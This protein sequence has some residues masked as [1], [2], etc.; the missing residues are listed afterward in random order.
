MVSAWY[1]VVTDENGDPIEDT[2]GDIIDI[3]DLED[4]DI[5]AFAN[6][7]LRKG[8]EMHEKIGDVDVVQH[9]TFEKQERESLGLGVGVEG[10][11]VK[12]RVN[13]DELWAKIKSGEYAELSIAG[14]AVRES[15]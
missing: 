12:L 8:G 5:D 15:L 13:N 2:Q 3:S 7:G 4:A 10:G 1:S 9:F 14:D 11:I 6:G